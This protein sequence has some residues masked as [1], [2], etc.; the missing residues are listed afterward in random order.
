MIFKMR[1]N[2][3]VSKIYD[4]DAETEDDARRIALGK[5]ERDF[6][7]SSKDLEDGR[8]GYITLLCSG[9]KNELHSSANYCARCGRPRTA[10]EVKA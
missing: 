7:F 8:F 5:A 4:V 2:F 3:Y 10:S 6:D 1:A 9:C